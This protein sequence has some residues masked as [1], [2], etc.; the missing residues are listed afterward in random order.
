MIFI[1][2]FKFSVISFSVFEMDLFDIFSTG[3]LTFNFYTLLFESILKSKISG[4]LKPKLGLEDFV[5]SE[6]AWDWFLN[7]F[8]L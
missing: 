2:D 6:L 8:L 5:Y 7:N 1:F 3:S 4:V